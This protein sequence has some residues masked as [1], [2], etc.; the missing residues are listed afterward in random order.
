M[1]AVCRL[2]DHRVLVSGL[3]AISV[4]KHTPLCLVPEPHHTAP[5][6][7]A[8]AVL[9]FPHPPPSSLLP[10]PSPS[11]LPGCMLPV[12]TCRLPSTAASYP[13]CPPHPLHPPHPLSTCADYRLPLSVP[14]RRCLRMWPCWATLRPFSRLLWDAADARQPRCIQGPTGRKGPGQRCVA[15]GRD[16]VE[17]VGDLATRPWRPDRR[18]GGLLGC[19]AVWPSGPCLL[20]LLERLRPSDVGTQPSH[21]LRHTV[22]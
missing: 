21:G 13:P 10:S 6:V 11:P 15:L 12:P 17:S 22:A 8:S 4:S 14:R 18:P 3:L 16:R 5:S 9:I 20:V 1:V 2:G 7:T 19:S